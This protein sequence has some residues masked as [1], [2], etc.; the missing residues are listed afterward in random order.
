MSDP[1]LDPDV[2]ATITD[3][4]IALSVYENGQ[5]LERTEIKLSELGFLSPPGEDVLV[6]MLAGVDDESIEIRDEHGT[7]ETNGDTPEATADD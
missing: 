4:F 5:C 7:I 6:S 2:V 1:D 3:E